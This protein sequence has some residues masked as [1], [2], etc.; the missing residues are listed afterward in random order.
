MIETARL[1]LR[2]PAQEDL[3]FRLAA[4][5]TPEVTRHLGGV[6]TPEQLAERHARDMAAFADHGIGFWTVTLRETGAPVG[7]CGLGSIGPKA[8]AP[9][10]GKREIGWTLAATAWGRGY[11]REAASAV[12]DHAFRVLADDEVWGQTSDSNAASSTL[13]RRLGFARRGDLDYV[14]D[15]YP[16]Q[17][18]PTTVY[19]LARA[20]W[21]EM[22]R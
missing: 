16:P 6:A 13:M 3:A 14:D 20:D 2:P 18:N 7:R 5:N 17:D 8:P 4:L 15:D 19:R 22:D 12:L 1:V 10:V 11:A 9:I 21:M